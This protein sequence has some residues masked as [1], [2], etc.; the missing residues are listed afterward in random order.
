MDILS[1]IRLPANQSNMSEFIQ[2]AVGCARSQGYDNKQVAHIRL[3]AEE[4]LVNI[5]RYAYDPEDEG[6][7][8]LTCGLDSRGKF[9]IEIEDRDGRNWFEGEEF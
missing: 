7:V 5:F 6:D 8:T 9:V 2:T 4:A 3:A 1:R